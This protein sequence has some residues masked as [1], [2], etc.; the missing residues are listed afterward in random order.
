MALGTQAKILEADQL[1]RFLDH[2]TK[3][4]RHWKRD[5]VMVLL[6]YR[7]GLRSKEIAGVTWAMVTD[8]AEQI[9]DI[10]SLRNGASKGKRGGREIPMHPELH[11]ALREL[12]MVAI[13]KEIFR[14]DW[15]VIYSQRGKGFS[16]NAVTVWF[17]TKYAEFGFKGASSH[18]GRRAF[19]TNAARKIVQAGGSLKD[20]QELAGHSSLA[21]TQRYIEGSSNAKRKVIDML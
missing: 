19:V 9:A 21:T 1:A 13:A 17:H 7:A 20:V 12:R 8:A 2:L 14:P 6:S 3:T 5:H 11:A 4:S 18:S 16:A 15:P 10:I